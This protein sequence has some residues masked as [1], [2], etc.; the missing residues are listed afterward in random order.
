MET[1]TLRTARL[2]LSVPTEADVDPIYVACQDAAIQRF[3][4]VPSPYSRQDAEGFI[5][6]AATRWSD[7]IEATWAIREHGRLA[8]MISL[9][10][11]TA[12]STAEIGFWMAPESRGRGLLTEASTAVIDWGFSHTGPALARIE[13]RAVVGNVASARV[14]RALGFRYE[15]VLRSA[16]GN[17]LGRYDSWIAGILPMDDRMP[18][19]WTVLDA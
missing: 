8:G 7:G 1:V 4:T 17:S 15:G 3:T 13:W 10:H 12:G 5:P 9:H 16:I 18:Q 14:A 2:E 11:L 19:T 6:F